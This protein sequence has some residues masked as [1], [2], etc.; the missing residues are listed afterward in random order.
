MMVVYVLGCIVGLVVLIALSMVGM[1]VVAVA[2]ELYVRQ[3]ADAARTV[4][5][6]M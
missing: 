6:W 1:V 4:L 2:I 5:N 3:V